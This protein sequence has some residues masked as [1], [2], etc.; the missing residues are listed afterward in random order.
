LPAILV[1]SLLN[2]VEP[3][4]LSIYGVKFLNNHYMQL[5]KEAAE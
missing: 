5:S 1:C 3:R 4:E 2:N